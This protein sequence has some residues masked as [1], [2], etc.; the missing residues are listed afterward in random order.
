MKKIIVIILTLFI[1][2]ISLSFVYAADDI[3][4]IVFE[5]RQIEGKIRRPQLVLIKAEQRPEFK[6]MVMQ[7]LSDF[8]I[9]EFSKGDVVEKS[10]YDKAF[11]LDGDII[12]NYVP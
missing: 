10:P 3:E 1:F 9:I 6:P 5:E 4:R 11:T 12:T 7:S 8:N 2:L